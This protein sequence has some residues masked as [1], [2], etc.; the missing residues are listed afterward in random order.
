MILVSVC[1]LI[2][3][4]QP[5]PAPR[6]EISIQVFPFFIFFVNNFL[7]TIDLG[8]WSLSLVENMMGYKAM[9]SDL[10]EAF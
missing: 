9:S 3:D 2:V 1:H 4:L 6:K 8:P 10:S 5:H 7:D